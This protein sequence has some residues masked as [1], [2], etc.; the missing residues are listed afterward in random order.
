MPKRKGEF[1]GGYT[2]LSSDLKP[3]YR[4]GKEG[5]DIVF[6]EIR[7]HKKYG[8]M[9]ELFFDVSMSQMMFKD[10]TKTQKKRLQKKF[11]KIKDNGKPVDTRDWVRPDRKSIR[12]ECVK[13]LMVLE[14]LEENSHK[15]SYESGRV[16]VLYSLLNSTAP[17]NPQTLTNFGMFDNLS[18]IM[19]LMKVPEYKKHMQITFP[20]YGKGPKKNWYKGLRETEEGRRMYQEWK[21]K[22][23]KE[24]IVKGSL[25]HHIEVK[26]E[27]N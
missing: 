18:V 16:D 11:G 3:E 19:N 26:E 22:C 21:A 12:N 5:T 25:Y 7:E 1:I 20:N 9:A 23:L 8:A 2:A 13:S 4:F 15:R 17:I 6:V 14:L 27:R 24:M 10:M